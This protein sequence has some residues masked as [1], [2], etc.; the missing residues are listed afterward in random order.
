MPIEIMTNTNRI[1]AEIDYADQSQLELRMQTPRTGSAPQKANEVLVSANIL[2]DLNIEEKIGAEI[3]IEF[4]NR[5]SGQMYHFDMVVSGIYDTPNEKSESVIV[6]KAFMEENPE[7]MTMAAAVYL[8]VCPGCVMG[9]MAGVTLALQG[10]PLSVTVAPISKWGPWMDFVSIYIIPIGAT[11]GAISWFYVMKKDVLMD[12]VG[13]GTDAAG[14]VFGVIGSGATATDGLLAAG[15]ATAEAG[16]ALTLYS[17][18][19]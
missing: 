8:G 14:D 9:L 12:A 7:M 4:K 18:T 6:S 15:A 19:K 16:R 11:L 5:Q 17:K 3:P 13:A 2:K 1:F 10:L